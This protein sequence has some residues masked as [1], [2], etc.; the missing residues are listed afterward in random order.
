MKFHDPANKFIRNAVYNR[1]VLSAIGE[2]ASGANGASSNPRD[3]GGGQQVCVGSYRAYL[4]YWLRPCRKPRLAKSVAQMQIETW[5]Y[6]MIDYSVM[7]TDA[8]KRIGQY[9]I[10]KIFLIVKSMYDTDY[11]ILIFYILNV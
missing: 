5:T 10:L 9:G 11:W 8:C 6:T 7:D 2:Y 4:L 3:A 1:D